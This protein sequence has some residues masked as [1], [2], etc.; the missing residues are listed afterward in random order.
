M[1]LLLEPEHEQFAKSIDAL[2][3]SASVP[4]IAWAWARGEHE[5]GRALW[6]RL[7]ELGVTALAVPE[8]HDGLG[9]TA[10]ELVTACRTL[11]AHAVPGPIVETLAFVPALFTEL[12]D[13]GERAEFLP[14]IAS[15][16]ALASVRWSPSIP[17]GVDADIAS[18]RAVLD[19]D[20]LSFGDLGER[21]G[22][23]DP[24]RHLFE[25]EAGEPLA[26]G[27]G[28]GQA[29]AR[30]FDHGA[31]ACAALLLG[32]G[33][34]ALRMAVDYVKARHQFGRP[35]GGFQA[36]KHRL[37]DAHI[38]LELA[39][40]LLHAAA[41]TGTSA[42]VSAAKR[43]CARAADQAARAALQAHG[44]IGYTAEHDLSLVLT[45]IRA[46]RFT[47]GTQDFHRDR[48]LT[49]RREAKPAC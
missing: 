38:A 14:R 12:S 16:E 42:D 34:S 22:S 23:V 35:I 10:V 49:L 5:P 15:G 33:E 39:R 40:P 9:A 48:L 32:L 43:S 8:E 17:F 19:G 7:A 13:V 44:A 24:T 21:H 4:D 28:L 18:V 31:L 41:V 25:L 1:K 20:S 27:S 2:L 6:R 11:G 47:W 3:R 26:T 37:A 30:A 29:A 36:V 46:L 45:K